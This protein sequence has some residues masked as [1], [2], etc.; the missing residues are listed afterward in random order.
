MSELKSKLERF[1]IMSDKIQ[2]NFTDI[3]LDTVNF[4]LNFNSVIILT[5]KDNQHH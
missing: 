1:K 3:W 4:K 5:P 2:K